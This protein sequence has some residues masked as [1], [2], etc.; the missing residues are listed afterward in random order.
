MN[1]VL[2]QSRG[3]TLR[4]VVRQRNAHAPVD[5]AFLFHARDRR[6][7]SSGLRDGVAKND[8]SKTKKTIE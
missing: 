5:L 4:A 1:L 6:T 2:Y 3:A 7:S 8:R